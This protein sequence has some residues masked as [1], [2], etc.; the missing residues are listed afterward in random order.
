MVLIS[1]STWRWIWSEILGSDIMVCFSVSSVN[2][3]HGR[4][5]YICV[6][7]PFNIGLDHCEG[8]FL[9]GMMVQI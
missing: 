1:E 6:I 2:N 7:W 8:G 5:I 9:E 3:E 4:A